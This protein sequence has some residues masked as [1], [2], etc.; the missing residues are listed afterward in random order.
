MERTEKVASLVIP[1]VIASAAGPSESAQPRQARRVHGSDGRVRRPLR[2]ATRLS[3]ATLV[4]A[5]H[6]TLVISLAGQHA[7]PRAAAPAST[8]QFVVTLIPPLS[9]PAQARPQR[10][11]GASARLNAPKAQPPQLSTVPVP[12]PVDLTRLASPDWYA[13]AASVAKA[14]AQRAAVAT[15]A[16]VLGQMPTGKSAVSGA[17]DRNGE[18]HVAGHAYRSAYGEL[19]AWTGSRCY[20]TLPAH[21]AYPAS[22]LA[23]IVRCVASGSENALLLVNQKDEAPTKVWD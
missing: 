19:V 16:R 4:I 20:A 15:P 14:A 7:A 8:A 1:P 12:P 17:P 9:H 23:P 11:E 10:H 21:L 18:A 22:T 5:C 2:I 13:T 3:A 6:V